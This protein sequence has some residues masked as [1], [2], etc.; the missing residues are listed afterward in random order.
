MRQLLS[1][2][3]GIYW[4]LEEIIDPGVWSSQKFY[5]DVVCSY[6]ESDSVWLDLGCGHKLFPD[7]RAMPSPSELVKKCKL[8]VG[9]D[10]EL[11]SLKKNRTLR[12]LLIAD[13]CDIPLAE[14]TF[15]RITANMVMEHIDDPVHEFRVVK[16]LLQPDGIFIFHTPNRWHYITFLAH[17]VPQRIKNMIIKFAEGRDED[18]IFPTFY[19]INTTRS[20]QRAAEEA[21]LEIVA[22]HKVSTSS[23]PMIVMLGPLVILDLLLRRLTRLEFLENFRS[24]FVVVLQKKPTVHP[25]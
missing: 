17:F 4:K 15:N 23:A 24:N 19:R 3:Y 25:T 9:I 14:N 16:R 18:D 7:W 6:I 12:E 10:Y 5:A 8:V 2:I 11:E 21:G 20:I 1:S 22:L 13:I